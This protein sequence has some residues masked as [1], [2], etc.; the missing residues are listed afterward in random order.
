MQQMR[1]VTVIL[2]LFLLAEHSSNATDGIRERRSETLFHGAQRCFHAGQWE[3]AAGWFQEF[4]KMRPNSP[5]RNMATLLRAQ[6]LYQVRK[7][8]ECFNELK[9]AEESSGLLAAEY[10]FW[11]AECRYREAE[12]A[13]KNEGLYRVAAQLFAEVPKSDREVA[14]RVSEATAHARLEDWPKV[15]ELLQ[16][17]STSFQQYA[18]TFEKSSLVAQGRLILAEALLRQNL[19]EDA[20]HI[21]DQLSALDLADQDRW[22]HQMQFSR[23][24]FAQKNFPK[25]LDIL[26]ELLRTAENRMPQ[27]RAAQAI[28]LIIRVHKELG[29]FPEAI[30]MCQNLLQEGMPMAVRRRG[31]L[32]SIDLA[33]SHGAPLNISQLHQQSAAI[34]KGDSLAVYQVALGDIYLMEHQRISSSE[35]FLPQGERLEK[36]RD[37]Y[38]AAIGSTFS[39][40]A[41]IGLGWNS[42]RERKYA[43]S[44]ANFI[45]AASE[46]PD[47]AQRSQSK[48]K[49]IESAFRAGDVHN[50]LKIGHNFLTNAPPSIFRDSARALMVR[51]AIQ[52]ASTDP[53]SLVEARYLFSTLDAKGQDTRKHDHAMLLLARAESHGSNL[54]KARE[55]LK[56]FPVDAA[57]KPA[58]ELEAARTFI[59]GKDWPSAIGRYEAWLET[60]AGTSENQRARVAFDLGWLHF[61]NKSPAKTASIYTDIVKQFPDTPEASRAQMWM[62]D[63]LFNQNID[64]D[65]VKA[66]ESYQKV[67]DMRNCPANLKYR[68]SLMAGRA[69]LARRSFRNAREYFRLIVN[70]KECPEAIKIEAKFALSDTAILNNAEFEEA[71]TILESILNSNGKTSSLINLQTHGRIGDCHLQMAAEDPNRYLKAQEA[72]RR[73]LELSSQ[74]SDDPPARYRAMMGMAQ[75]LKNMPEED[76][77]KRNKNLIQ[78]LGWAKKVFEGATSAKTELEPFWIRQSGLMSADLQMRA[79]KPM[80][81]IAT[82]RALGQHF[83]KMRPLLDARINQIRQQLREARP[84]KSAEK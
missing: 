71:I 37:Q 30:K 64:A 78:A 9:N 45:Q 46:L 39:G 24:L 22:R 59:L 83:G 66:E 12:S 4:I 14:A 7:Y 31:L 21:L 35:N 48:F 76:M 74:M 53:A 18:A 11:M 56:K 77:G 34:L 67:R 49:A 68:A 10:K 75:S 6:S 50:T 26:G 5:R 84:E 15:V 51:A 52:K 33:V 44:Y 62:A 61:L 17:A 13:S 29:N 69:A 25:A 63:Y 2:F 28:E 55:L 36:S 42:W 60:H 16:P 38:R 65:Y 1:I 20:A 82:L 54:D 58:V 57:L 79:G 81:E 32:L 73:V 70:D 43:D 27:L 8:R 19:Y 3:T 40:H 72:Y 41:R 47:P 80:E 23:A